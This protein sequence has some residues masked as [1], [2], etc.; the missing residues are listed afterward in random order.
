MKRVMETVTAFIN[1]WTTSGDQLVSLVSGVVATSAAQEGML[2]V[3]AIG[4][5]QL[6]EF[7]SDRMISSK[8][9]FHAPIKQN[10][11]NTFCQPKKKVSKAQAKAKVQ[12]QDR[13]LFTRLLVVSR[14]RNVDLKEVL[15]YPLSNISHPLA[16]ADGSMAKTNKALLLQAIEKDFSN[17]NYIVESHEASETAIIIDAMALIQALPI[18]SIP[19]TFRLLGGV[20]LR[21]IQSLA[22]RYNAQRVDFVIDVYRTNSIKNVER[23]RRVAGSQTPTVLISN[24]EV[25]VPGNWK[26]FLSSGT[27]KSSLLEFLHEYFQSATVHYISKL[28]STTVNHCYEISYKTNAPED[29]V[30]KEI[31]ELSSNHEEADTRLL[32]HAHH[33]NGSGSVPI[34][35]SPDTD[36]AILSLWH[37]G[38]FSSLRMLT[39]TKDRR[40]LLDIKAMAAEI[41]AHVIDSLI[42]LHAMTGCDSVSSF[43]G[44]GKKTV[45]QLVKR[46]PSAQAAM[47]LLGSSFE[48]TPEKFAAG[49]SFACLLYGETGEDINEC[50]YRKFCTK[51]SSSSNLPP[52]RSSLQQH[53]MRANFVAKTWKSALSAVIEMARPDRN[54]WLLE[55]G[56]YVF[57]WHTREVAPKDVLKI[58]FCSCATS[59]CQGRCSCKQANLRCTELCRCTECSNT[60]VENMSDVDTDDES[61][62][63]E[64][65]N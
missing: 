31:T 44:K 13:S 61:D 17:S 11:L 3:V 24:G 42:G 52:C 36:V 15:S 21:S 20:V 30:I 55:D 29:T 56:Y 27:N 50:R 9:D 38:S 62:E 18:S 16:T 26:A 33:A 2:N 53:I 65:M 5:T 8:K 47:Q 43:N 19:A 40:R 39:G 23:S 45:Y 14:T 4:E 7:V 10:K 54:G 48:M 64:E 51:A 34:I 22:K 32:L 35:V 63:E 6:E 37:S 60:S 46:N 41:G 28:Y 1:P 58:I 12:E 25:K 57:C 49:E 59:K